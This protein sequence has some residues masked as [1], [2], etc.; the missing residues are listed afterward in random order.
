MKY[1]LPAGYTLALRYLAN[2][3][4]SLS[5]TQGKRRISRTKGE[6][7]QLFNHGWKT[8]PF[9]GG[10]RHSVRAALCVLTDGG[11]PRR[12]Q[13]HRRDIFVETSR[14]EFQAWSEATSSEYAA[15]DGAPAFAVTFLQ[16][17]RADGAGYKSRRRRKESLTCPLETKE[18]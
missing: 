14:K 6:T 15:P 10:A 5:A 1:N 11:Q 18:I 8:M 7:N 12:S 2:S 4:H 9:T 3:Q 16:R 13:R 17:C